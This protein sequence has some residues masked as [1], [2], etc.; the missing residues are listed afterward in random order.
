MCDHRLWQSV[1]PLL[2][3]TFDPI[4]IQFKP[5]FKMPDMLEDITGALD[6]EAANL[7]G[8]SMGGYVSLQYALK[9]PH[10]INKLVLIGASAQNLTEYE[11][12]KRKKIVGYLKGNHYSG[13]NDLRLKQFI[14]SKHMGGPIAQL[15]KAMDKDLGKEYLLA[16]LAATAERP[17]LLERLKELDFPVLIIGA[18]QDQLIP[19]QQTLNLA[20]HFRYAEV[21][22]ADDCGHMSPL[23]AP[24]QVSQWINQFLT[25]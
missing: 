6:L 3:E 12:A 17:S 20:Q 15:I 18:E 9:Y 11:Q 13:I 7:V 19:P 4:A 16:Q 14:H 25:Q 10:A 23:E 1:W 8:F 21:K 5:H 24:E 22:I 2:H